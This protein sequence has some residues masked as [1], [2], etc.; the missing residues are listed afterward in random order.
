LVAYV[1]AESNPKGPLLI[2]TYQSHQPMGNDPS[3]HARI[4]GEYLG[5]LATPTWAGHV[6]ARVRYRNRSDRTKRKYTGE[7]PVHLPEDLKPKLPAPGERIECLGRPVPFGMGTRIMSAGQPVGWPGI[8]I[9]VYAIEVA[10][11]WLSSAG[12]L[13]RE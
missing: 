4:R 5:L 8:R 9:W 2:L 7:I 10:G 1:N 3:C 13:P 12:E 6:V 11:V